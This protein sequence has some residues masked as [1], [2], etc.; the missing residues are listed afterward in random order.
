MRLVTIINGNEELT[1][2]RSPQYELETTIK[3]YRWDFTYSCPDIPE[4]QHLSFY[5]ERDA[6]LAIAAWLN[7]SDPQGVEEANQLLNK[8]NF[9]PDLL[10]NAPPADAMEMEGQFVFP[11]KV[12]GVFKK[13]GGYGFS[14]RMRDDP[15]TVFIVKTT[16]SSLFHAKAAMYSF[17]RAVNA[18]LEKEK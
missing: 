9:L 10:Q 13:Q 2:D 14:V 3:G 16:M 15:Y 17:V 1:V 12:A 7:I 18:R 8:T 4:Q 11:I 5:N 6:F